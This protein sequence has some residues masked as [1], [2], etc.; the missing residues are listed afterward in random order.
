M[1]PKPK[2]GFRV[3]KRSVISQHAYPI[4]YMLASEATL[5]VQSRFLRPQ[6][7]DLI[8]TGF[9]VVVFW[10]AARR[11][12]PSCGVS[13]VELGFLYCARPL[14][15]RHIL[16]E[17]F[18]N[19]CNNEAVSP[20]LDL[21]LPESQRTIARTNSKFVVPGLPGS[22][23][24]WD[25]FMIGTFHSSTKGRHVSP[26]QHVNNFKFCFVY[27]LSSRCSLFLV[28]CCSVLRRISFR[29]RCRS[30][31]RRHPLTHERPA[32]SLVCSR[33]LVKLIRT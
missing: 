30:C 10:C 26:L 28:V 27:R 19:K 3:T 31:I 6:F 21:R 15:N 25:Y 2:P 17:S 1:K 23:A 4:R 8:V 18:W 9:P 24:L 22:S 13:Y 33:R 11:H 32:Q 5:T 14:C 20:G 7:H 29:F 16:S 12:S